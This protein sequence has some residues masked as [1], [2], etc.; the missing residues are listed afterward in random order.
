MGERWRE[1]GG[2]EG[3]G[4]EGGREGRREREGEG[5]RERGGR[6]GGREGRR[7]GGKYFS[8]PEQLTLLS[9]MGIIIKPLSEGRVQISHLMQKV[10]EMEGGG[11]EGRERGGRE[12][13]REG[14]TSLTQSS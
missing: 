2:K 11:R 1:E 9:D 14:N 12:G 4:R 5:R 10:G 8:D 13:G 7:E 6:E 3:E